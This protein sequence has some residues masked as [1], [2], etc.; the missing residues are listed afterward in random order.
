MKKLIAFLLVL[1]VSPVW[2]V[3][4]VPV[5]PQMNNSLFNDLSANLACLCGCGV[6]LKDCP[7]ESCSFAIPTRKSIWKM[8][9]GGL[10]RT[11]IIDNLVKE[12]GEVI[13]AA[14]TFKGFNL[15]AW[16]TPFIL[17]FVVGFGIVTLLR[18]WSR[19]QKLAAAAASLEGG[20][21]P[22]KTDK[23]DPQYKRLHDE[24]EKFES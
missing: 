6:T 20:P 16:I 14:P 7:H 11:Q 9:D 23:N 10:D 3:E 12:R 15:L 17:M 19:K 2:A 24:L 22:E 5:T 21:A 13:L 1:T 8:I 4:T 18:S